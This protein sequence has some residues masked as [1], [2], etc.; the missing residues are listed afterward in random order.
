M[1]DSPARRAVTSATLSLVVCA[2]CMVA[3]LPPMANATLASMPQTVLLGVALATSLV[4]HWVFIGLAA[5]RMARSVPFWLGF[6][7]LLFP[8]GS[9][10]TLVLLGW[11]LEER[12]PALSV[13]AH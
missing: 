3:F 5:H 8:I 2:A 12:E 1:H 10:A 11:L 7:V 13:P 6:S 4:L 9:V